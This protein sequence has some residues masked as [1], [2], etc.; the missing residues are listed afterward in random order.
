MEQVGKVWRR[1]PPGKGV[2]EKRHSF[3]WGAGNGRGKKLY[4]GRAFFRAKGLWTDE[5]GKEFGEK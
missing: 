4:N 5:T 2:K 3:Y 1:L